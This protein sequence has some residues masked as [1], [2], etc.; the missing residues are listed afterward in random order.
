MLKQRRQLAKLEQEN[1]ML[2]LCRASC[3]GNQFV[4][5]LG[6]V[7]FGFGS[8]VNSLPSISCDC[9]MLVDWESVL[10]R[11]RPLAI[12]SILPWVVFSLVSSLITGMLVNCMLAAF[13]DWQQLWTWEGRFR[14]QNDLDRL[15]RWFETD[16]MKFDKCNNRMWRLGRRN[17]H[18]YRLQY[19]CPRNWRRRKNLLKWIAYG[20]DCLW[21][22]WFFVRS[23]SLFWV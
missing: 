8:S 15:K 3:L 6:W 22:V 18:K 17:V 2:L 16:K 1:R 4:L 9:S 21:F 11:N 13:A 23:L 7:W 12:P 5:G 14:I 19:T 10:N 20:M